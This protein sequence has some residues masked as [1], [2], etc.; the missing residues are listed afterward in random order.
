M[1]IRIE[2]RVVTVVSCSAVGAM[3]LDPHGA[4]EWLAAKI[5]VNLCLCW[6]LEDFEAIDYLRGKNT[7]LDRNYYKKEEP[8]GGDSA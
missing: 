8:P 1:V 5:V 3:I 7:A 2:N 6:W 4:E